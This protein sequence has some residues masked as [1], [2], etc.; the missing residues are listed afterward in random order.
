MYCIVIGLE[1][2]SEVPAGEPYFR[3]PR[4]EGSRGRGGPVADLANNLFWGLEQ[5]FSSP[6]FIVP[7]CKTVRRDSGGL[8]MCSLTRSDHENTDAHVHEIMYIL[9]INHIELL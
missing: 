7:T 1:I 2:E 5:S 6:G 3:N 4:L 8:Q 9:L